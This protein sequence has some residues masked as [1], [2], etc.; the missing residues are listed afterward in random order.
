MRA[1]QASEKEQA[2]ETCGS[3]PG[4]LCRTKGNKPACEPHSARYKAWHEHG[5]ATGAVKVPHLQ[6]SNTF[7]PECE[8]V[9]TGK[10]LNAILREAGIGTTSAFQKER[11][12]RAILQFAAL[13]TD[14]RSSK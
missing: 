1:L 12:I 4:E 5:V 2:C 14:A 8:Y 6:I 13:I 7:K 3:Q 11:D 10:M 9:V